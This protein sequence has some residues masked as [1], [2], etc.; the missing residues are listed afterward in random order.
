MNVYINISQKYLICRMCYS[1]SVLTLL[2]SDSYL[3]SG[4]CSL[5]NMFIILENLIVSVKL[6]YNYIDIFIFY[7]HIYTLQLEQIT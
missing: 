3:M 4:S 7:I 6:Y 1:I 5:I 2:I